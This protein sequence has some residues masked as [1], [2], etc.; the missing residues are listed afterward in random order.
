MAYN[1]TSWTTGD[2]SSTVENDNLKINYKMFG[3]FDMSVL[4]NTHHP[5]C[6][7]PQGLAY[8]GD[9]WNSQLA[10]LG[11]STDP[12]TSLTMT[13]STTKHIL[14]CMW[15]LLDAITIKSGK[16]IT[17]SDEASSTNTINHHIMSYDIASNGDL[18]NGV[19]LADATSECNV[20]TQASSDLNV[21][22]A[23]VSAGKVIICFVENE[24]GTDD[25]TTN[26]TLKYIIQGV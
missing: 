3:C 15:Y 17:N 21:I 14:P 19:V 6:A 2:T 7:T 11:S 18:S 25:I 26:V 8:S 5:I 12:G 13:S 20:T 16:L 1:S 10:N 9:A 23:D 22:S 4:S 24:D